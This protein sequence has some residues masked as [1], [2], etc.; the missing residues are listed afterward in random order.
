MSFPPVLKH[1]RKM[2]LSALLLLG[3]AALAQ[4][5]A[6]NNRF[7]MKLPQGLPVSNVAR[8]VDYSPRNIH[9]ERRDDC[10]SLQKSCNGGC[11]SSTDVCC[12]G[13][14]VCALLETCQDDG[15]CCKIT[16]GEE[17]C[18]GG[19]DGSSSD[20]SCRDYEESCGSNCMPTDSVCCPDQLTYCPSGTTCDGDKCKFDD[21]DAAGKLNAGLLMAATLFTFAIA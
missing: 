19:D 16:V 13:G 12:D 6:D 1:S 9:H 5:S 20:T 18:S 8:H 4:A 11:I 2:Y 21:D 17:I 10:S 7:S 3:A 15:T 14:G